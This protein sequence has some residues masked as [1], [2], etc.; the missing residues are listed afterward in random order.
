MRSVRELSYQ[1]HRYN[2]L[3]FG[4]RLPPVRISIEKS[5]EPGTLGGYDPDTRTII[6]SIPGQVSE[7]EVLTTLI[8]EMVHVAV[9]D[10]EDRHGA[11]FRAELQRL[12][13]AGSEDAE[14]E[15]WRIAGDL[16]WDDGWDGDESGR[17]ERYQEDGA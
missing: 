5:D 11:P 15:V 17:W 7:R 1:Y 10:P 6:L 2:R 8:H 16:M 9:P 12:A 3:Y 14:F 4:G 13:E